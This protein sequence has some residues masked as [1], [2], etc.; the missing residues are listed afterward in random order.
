MDSISRNHSKYLL[1]AH[2][3]VVTKYRKQLLIK[4]GNEIKQI[5]SDI[6]EEKDFE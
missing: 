3:I 1:M 5:L 6:A 4:Y 2:L